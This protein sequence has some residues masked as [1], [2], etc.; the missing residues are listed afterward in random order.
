MKITMTGIDT[1]AV[2]ITAIICATLVIICWM[3][4]SDKK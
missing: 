3:G 2:L 4:Q 1:T